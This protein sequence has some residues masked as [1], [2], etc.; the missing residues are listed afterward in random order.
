[1]DLNPF[2]CSIC[3]FSITT[4]YD[5]KRHWDHHIHLPTLSCISCG[6]NFETEDL[7]FDHM[8]VAHVQTKS[9]NDEDSNSDLDDDESIL[10]MPLKVEMNMSQDYMTKIEPDESNYS[11]KSSNG[12]YS[13]GSRGHYCEVCSKSFGRRDHLTR[14]MKTVHLR[15]TTYPCSVCSESLANKQ[16][17]ICHFRTVHPNSPF[18]SDT[19]S[20]VSLEPVEK[21]IFECEQCGR[22]FNRND[23]LRRHNRLIHQK[24]GKAECPTCAVKFRTFIKLREHM[25]EVHMDPGPD[26]SCPTCRKVFQSP[27]SLSHHIQVSHVKSK[28][29]ECPACQNTFQGKRELNRHVKANHTKGQ[30]HACQKCGET[31]GAKFELTQHKKSFHTRKAKILQPSEHP[32]DNFYVLS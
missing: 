19:A 5:L 17:L 29:H 21:Q 13:P 10:E 7:L 32:M 22:V 4:E 11:I 2:Q 27:A 18:P 9:I 25:M 24:E 30:S 20:E 16:E 28:K 6:G 8:V 1:M 3:G 23:H 31:F 15:S 14:H 26:I 12:H